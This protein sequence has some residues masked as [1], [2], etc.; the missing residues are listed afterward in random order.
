M[1][2][3]KN[4]LCIIVLVQNNTKVKMQLESFKVEYHSGIPVYK[5]IINIVKT[6]LLN[7]EIIIGDK[8]PSIR[9]LAVR[10]NINPNTVAKAYRELE[11]TNVIESAG[12]NGS[13]ISASKDKINGITEEMKKEKMDEIYK[14]VLSEAKSYSISEADLKKMFTKDEK[15]E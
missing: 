14:R 15:D 11:L 5:Q 10:L 7:S 6:A 2:A 8:L 12:R 3:I 1:L 9:S 4:S 13:R